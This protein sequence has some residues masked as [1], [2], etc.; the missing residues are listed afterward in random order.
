MQPASHKRNLRQQSCRSQGQC[1][2]LQYDGWQQCQQGLEHQH[3]TV[4][5]GK[6]VVYCDNS[7]LCRNNYYYA[8]ATEFVLSPPPTLPA[9]HTGIADSGFSGFYFVPN[10]P[11]AN[12]NP[13]A[14]TVG[15]HVANNHPKLLVASATLSSAS[16]LPPA[17]ECH[18]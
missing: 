8:L 3:L 11:V 15:V 4:W 7:N 14:L 18:A 2:C 1:N 5:D 12:Y 9:H 17:A 16:P 13:Q 6:Y 10:A